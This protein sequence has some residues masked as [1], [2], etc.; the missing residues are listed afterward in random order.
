[1]VFQRVSRM[2]FTL[3]RKKPDYKLRLEEGAYT[4]KKEAIGINLTKTATGLELTRKTGN[5]AVVRAKAYVLGVEKKG[6]KG[7]TG[8]K[9]DVNSE[10]D[11]FKKNVNTYE[12]GIIPRS[13]RKP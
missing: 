7:V 5:K 1:M 12:G 2:G 4:S 3:L 8:F 6:D 13:I 11:R 10:F 9:R